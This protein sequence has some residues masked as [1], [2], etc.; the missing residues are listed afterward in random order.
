MAI[1]FELNNA[2]KLIEEHNKI[3]K[4]LY[5]AQTCKK[6]YHQN[7]TKAL[8][9]LIRQEVLKILEN[10]P[11]EEINRGENQFRLKSLRDK[12]YNSIADLANLT[13]RGIS[14][15]RGISGESA[16]AIKQIVDDFELKAR[17]GIK[18][19]LSV[20]EKS[21]KSTQLV[22]SISQYYQ[23]R[24]IVANCRKLIKENELKIRSAIENLSNVKGGVKW[25]FTSKAKKQEAIDAYNLLLENSKNEYAK[26]ARKIFARFEKTKKLTAADAWKDFSN[27]SVRFF[28]IIEEINPSVLGNDDNKYGLPEELART[29]QEEPFLSEGLRCE[30]RRYQEWGVKYILHQKQVLLGDEMGLGKTVQA[31]AAMVSLNNKGN[32]HFIVV[33]PASVIENW[34][35]EIRKMSFL[36]VFK[37]HGNDKETMLQEW[38]KFGG[39]AVTTYETTSVFDFGAEMKVSLLVVDEA[40][41]IK[42]PNANRTKNVKRIG[43]YAE[44]KLFM[45]GT[46]LENRVDEM[47]ELIRMLSPGVADNLRGMEAL[48]M[49]PQFRETVAPVYYRRKRDDVLSELPELIESKEWCTLNGEEEQRYEEA[50]LNKN[51]S[52]ARRVSWNIDDLT[53]SSKA[54]RLIDLVNEAESEGRKVIVFSFFIDTINK[55]SKLLGDRCTKP[56]KGSVSPQQRQ[57]IID[58]FD[59]ASAGTVLLAQIQAGGTGL[60][61][62]SASVI[63]LCEPQFKPS[64]E[65]QAI[66]RAYRMGQTRNV[67]VY[68]LL[69][70]NSVDEKLLSLLESKQTIFDVFADES[71]AALETKEIDNGT[72]GDII[73]EEVERIKDKYNISKE[74]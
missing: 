50:I 35:R 56:I 47:V 39:V 18:I 67:L 51:Y 3:L 73:E 22:K 34:C 4:N 36:K 24:V 64:T 11:I 59:N 54:A 33:C 44:R 30:L 21:K 40:H 63:I 74:S 6:V 16:K 53:K 19:K 20:D 15:V 14:Y 42:N 10:V 66:S 46:A 17:E 62:Q 7:V 8:E 49:A 2:K 31:I 71:V 68:R 69:C 23:S 57:E 28:N 1:P 38:I 55:I 41:Y 65:R 58:E 29:I 25:F 45:T 13:A 5:V 12:G 72:F 70:E 32:T 37:I 9:E 61:I 27:N 26:T 60:N 52:D 43:M 48:S